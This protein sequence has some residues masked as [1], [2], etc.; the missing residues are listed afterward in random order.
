M[1]I[2]IRNRFVDIHLFYEQKQKPQPTTNNKLVCTYSL[3]SDTNSNCFDQKF[4]YVLS[5]QHFVFVKNVY[6]L[7]GV[8][9][10]ISQQQSPHPDVCIPK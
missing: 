6:P 2:V 8:D 9:L 3:D 4:G 1:I 5:R 10:K 7:V